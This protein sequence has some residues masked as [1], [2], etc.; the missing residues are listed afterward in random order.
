[1]IALLMIVGGHITDPFG[2]DHEFQTGREVDFTVVFVAACGAAVFLA[3]AAVRLFSHPSRNLVEKPT[4]EAPMI[5]LFLP[6]ATPPSA[7]PPTLRI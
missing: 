7:S 2:L 4:R 6:P 5:A 1:M 3:L